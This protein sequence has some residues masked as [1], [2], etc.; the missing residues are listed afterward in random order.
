MEVQE[1]YTL[2]EI[3]FFFEHKSVQKRIDFMEEYDFDD[4][5]LSYYQEFLIENKEESDIDYLVCLI[6]LAEDLEIYDEILLEKYVGYLKS[7]KSIYLKLTILDYF[8][9]FPLEE[10]QKIGLEEQLKSQLKTQNIILKNQVF[11]N[12]IALKTIDCSKYKMQFF[13]S[14]L[15]TDD[16]KSLIRVVSKFLNHTVFFDVFT[17]KEVFELLKIL[18]T[19]KLGKAL[20]NSVLELEKVV[21]EIE[22]DKQ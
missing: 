5:Y 4:D 2:E 21:M 20:E 7:K 14:L 1:Q 15:Q 17:S 16:Y 11:L 9:N 10:K 18:K 8:I 13:Q 3:K 12:L 19:K 22:W 6:E